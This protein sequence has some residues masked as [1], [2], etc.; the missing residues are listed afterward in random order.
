MKF[1]NIS[2]PSRCDVCHQ[3]DLFDPQRNFCSRCQFIGFKKIKNNRVNNILKLPFLSLMIL[4]GFCNFRFPD[5]NKVWYDLSSIKQS[6]VT[7]LMSYTDDSAD[8]LLDDYLTGVDDF[9]GHKVLQV[10]GINLNSSLLEQNI[11]ILKSIGLIKEKG[12][13]VKKYQA[14]MDNY[15]KNIIFNYVTYLK[16]QIFSVEHNLPLKIHKRSTERETLAYSYKNIV[17]IK[18]NNFPIVKSI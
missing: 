9:I 16:D 2:N 12:F 18:F 10:F 11:H 5:D 8:N 13:I 14:S 1:N 4:N 17:G 3:R 7:D 15:T 6:L